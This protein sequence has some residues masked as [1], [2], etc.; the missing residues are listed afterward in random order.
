MFELHFA[1]QVRL[2]LAES[3]LRRLPQ[4]IA[5]DARA[6][7]RERDAANFVFFRQFETLAVACCQQFRLSLTAITVDWPDSM[8]DVLGRELSSGCRHSGSRGTTADAGT[9]PIKLAH[10]FR[11]ARTVDSAI[12]AASAC[13]RGVSCVDD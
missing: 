9:D 13:Q 8:K 1:M 11:A 6:D 7:R 10:D 5:V 3:D 12:H 2:D 4:R